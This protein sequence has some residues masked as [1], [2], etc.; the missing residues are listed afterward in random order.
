MGKFDI[1]SITFILTDAKYKQWL[2]CVKINKKVYKNRR[3]FRNYDEYIKH[4]ENLNVPKNE[5]EW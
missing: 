5:Q 3:S 2:V 1:F 4:N